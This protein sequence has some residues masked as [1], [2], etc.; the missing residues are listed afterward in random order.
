LL[1]TIPQRYEKGDF[2]QRCKHCVGELTERTLLLE[3]GRIVFRDWETNTNYSG[4]SNIPPGH[5]HGKIHMVVRAYV[6]PA[7]WKVS[8]FVYRWRMLKAD[9]ATPPDGIGEGVLDETDARMR[10]GFAH[11]ALAASATHEGLPEY[12]GGQLALAE[13]QTFV[14]EQN[15]Y[16]TSQQKKA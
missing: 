10:W 13:Q 2:M 11:P 7:C 8:E 9:I 12:E 4:I 15:E 14:S 5:A 6:C 1:R 3:S 16:E